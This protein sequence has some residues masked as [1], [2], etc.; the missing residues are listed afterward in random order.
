MG[1]EGEGFRARAGA[2]TILLMLSEADHDTTLAM[3]AEMATGVRADGR[4]PDSGPEPHAAE[5]D[6]EFLY[7]AGTIA[8]WL[9]RRPGGGLDLD[10]EAMPPL[11]ALVGGWASATLHALAAEP[12]TAA[13]AQRRMGTLPLDTVRARI[14]AMHDSGLLEALPRGSEPCY[15]VTDWARR[16]IAPLAAAA[17]M[18]MRFPPGDTAPIAVADVKAGFRLALPLLR[19]PVDA[20][21]S[22]ALA[23]ALEPEVSKDPAGVTA[24]VEEG[25]VVAVEPGLAADAG[26]RAEASAEDWLNTVMEPGTGHVELSGD[27][28]LAVRLLDGLHET[29]FG[30]PLRPIAGAPWPD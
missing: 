29:L 14:E 16:G 27:G 22:C 3:V 5:A 12:F 4:M 6:R 30:G 24:R 2:L 25:R 15:A 7:V 19:L 18:E 23:M 26:A 1:G 21:G 11:L 28:R 17:R 9:R 20:S 13:E 8:D 10:E